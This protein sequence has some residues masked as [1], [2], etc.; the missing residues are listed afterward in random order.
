VVFSLLARRPTTLFQ[1]LWNRCWSH[2]WPDAAAHYDPPA[3][4]SPG[5]SLPWSCPA[6]ERLSTLLDAWREA[7]EKRSPDIVWLRSLR[8]P[9]LGLGSPQARLPLGL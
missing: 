6:L 1:C 9:E 3:G 7:K 8:P 2:D 4:G 5:E